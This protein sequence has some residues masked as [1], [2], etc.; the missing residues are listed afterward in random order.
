MLLLM[1]IPVFE[2][3]YK[4]NIARYI[5]AKFE[6][7]CEVDGVLLLSSLQLIGIHHV[8]V[9]AVCKAIELLLPEIEVCTVLHK[10]EEE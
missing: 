6:A 1:L 5:G 4:Y 7:E 10:V 3:E 8:V 2:G 9:Y